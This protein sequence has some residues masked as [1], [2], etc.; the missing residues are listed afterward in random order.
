MDRLGLVYGAI[1]MRRT[2]DG[3]VF[4]EI[5]PAGE[6]R[7]VEDRTGQPIT[8]AMADLLVSLDRP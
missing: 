5:N 1:D 2:V 4:L 8:A 6:W 7:F 3:D